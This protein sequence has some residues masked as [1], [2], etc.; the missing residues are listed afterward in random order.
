MSVEWV[1]RWNDVIAAEP[2][3]PGVWRRKEGGYR[4]RGRV[5]DPRTGKL[6]EVN[7]ALPECKRARE[8][9]VELEAELAKIRAGVP[10]VGT[11][12]MPSFADWAATVFERKCTTG[13]ISSAGSR[14]KWGSVLEHHLVP[15]FGPIYIDKLVREDIE[16]WKVQMLAPREHAKGEAKRQRKLTAGKYA[17]TTINTV[18]AI[19]RQITVEASQEFN[20]ADVCRT[21]DDVSTKTHRVYTYEEPNSI[22]PEDLPRFLG[23]LR[24]R[25]PQHYAFV[26]LGFAT[27]LRPSSLRPLRAKGPNADVKWDEAK[28][29]VRRSHSRGDEVMDTTKTGADQIIAL[30]DELLSVLQWHVDRMTTENERR[31]KRNP[32][33]AAAMDESDLLFPAEPNGRTNGGG[34]R[35]VSCLDKPFEDIARRIKLTYDVTPRAMRRTYQDIARAAGIRDVVTRAIS[36]HATETMQRLYSTVGDDEVRAGLAKVI[37]IAT[38]RER[39]AA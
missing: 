26:F 19:L 24:A 20:I 33:L 14:E 4:V 3:M 31:A 28:L 9:A 18:L 30:P 35:S 38:G 36:G 2:E 7:R 13:A 27:G 10:Q 22:K 25:Y 23:E 34:F 12:R 6:R 17:P 32:T 21:V 15:T 39:R 16:R 11:S 29:L 8:A 37:D 1:T 5:V